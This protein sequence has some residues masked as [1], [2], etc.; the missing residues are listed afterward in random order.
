V[1][2]VTVGQN[3]LIGQGIPATWT[4]NG[5]SWT[6]DN[7]VTP[8]R[9][10]SCM[11]FDTTRGRTVLYSSGRNL[12]SV[13]YYST[14][15]WAFDG[16]IWQQILP[17]LP[18]ADQFQQVMPLGLVYD[19]AR[20]AMVMVGSDYN[21]TFGN[22]PVQ[23]WEYRYL[24]RV[25]FDKQPQGQPLT[26][27]ATASFTA[28]AAGYGA[29]SYQW[30]RNGQNIANGPAPGGGTFAGATTATLTL[31]G[32]QAAD[33]AA[34]TCLVSN[35]CGGE[36]SDVA[37][38]GRLPADFDGDDDVDQ[39][40]F[41]VFEACGAGVNLPVANGCEAAD[42]NGDG[43]VNQSDFGRFQRCLSG[44]GNPA[45]ANCAN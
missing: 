10:N 22:V 2:H 8:L 43:V 41:A 35:A 28:Y 29:L 14:D 33:A 12:G 26:P 19:T 39:D 4:F 34:Y 30:Q 23:T 25:V 45:D 16:A 3:A 20:R 17:L 7:V 38:L 15:T 5:A 27:G 18:N 13:A 37:L 44:A 32:V 31:I 6:N 24:D 42:L 11:A 21:G 9:V 40:D 36:I 1:R